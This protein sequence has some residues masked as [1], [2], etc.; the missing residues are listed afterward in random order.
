[1]A[2]TQKARRSATSRSTMNSSGGA[3]GDDFILHSIACSRNGPHFSWHWIAR[4]NIRLAVWPKT[5][6]KTIFQKASK[7]VDFQQ[8]NRP[9]RNPEFSASPPCYIFLLV[10]QPN[11]VISRDL[12]CDS[13]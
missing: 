2:S 10:S 8:E 6:Q 12:A 1:M 11:Q 13:I 4:A 9:G 3:F 5:V 7:A